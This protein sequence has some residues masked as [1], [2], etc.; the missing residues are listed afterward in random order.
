MRTFYVLCCFWVC[1]GVAVAEDWA[2]FNGPTG[3]CKSG[4][5]GILKNWPAQGPPRVWDIAT[6]QGYCA[7]TIAHGKLFLFDRIGD[8][9]RLRCLNPANGQQQWSFTYLTDFVDMYGYDGGPRACPVA[10]GDRVYILGP[11]GMLHCLSAAD[12]AVRWKM[13]TVAKFGVVPNFFGVGAAPVIEGDKLIMQVGGSPPLSPPVI[14]GRTQGNGTGIVALN[15]LTGEVVYKLSDELASYAVPV[16]ATIGGRRWCFVFARGGLVGFDPGNGKQ[17]FH[18]PWR[19][20]IAE[21]VNASNPVVA[22]GMVLIS[23]CYGPGSS[24]LKVR[25]GGYDVAWKDDEKSRQKAMA[26]HMMTP[27]HLDGYVYGSSGRQ[28]G[29]AELRCI[30]I[31]TGKTA[32]S[33]P[34]L[35]RCSLLYVDGHFVALSETG[36]LLLVRPTHERF[37]LVAQTEEDLVEYPAWA[38]PVLSNGLLYLRGAGK[39]V[40]LRLIPESQ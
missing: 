39:L 35:N 19:A 21:S 23:E 33:Q 2:G 38:G 25:P 4:E 9:Q 13:D 5:K 18:Y 28:S 1:A 15:K 31:A 37:D 6:G 22:G 11:E 7:P 34:K 27:V 12:G 29:G 3:D 36:K 8:N 14:S 16:L 17:D 40:C 32:W 10:D 26:T 30:E 20:T 24:V